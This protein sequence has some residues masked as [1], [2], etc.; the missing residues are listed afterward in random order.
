MSNQ[1]LSNEPSLTAVDG[2]VSRAVINADRPVGT[3]DRNIYGHFAEHLGRCIYEGIWVGEDSDIPNTKGIRNDVL[4]ALQGLDIPV[5][6]W[7][8]GCFADEYHWKDGIGPRESRKRMVNTHWGGVVENNHF[9]THEFLLLCELLGCE[10]YINGNVG[11]GTVQEMQEWVEYMTFAGESPMSALRAAGGHEQPWKVRY[12]GVGNENWGCGGNMRPEYYADEYR[13]YQTYV[14][15][16]GDNKITRIACGANDFNYEWTEVLMREAASH[17]DA[18]TLH[19]YTVPFVWSEKGSATDFDTKAWFE[20]LRKALVMD[21]LVGKHKTIMDKYDPAKR[22]SL[23]VDEWGTWYDVEPGTNPGFLYQQNTMR[24]ALVAAATLHI[25]HKH[26]DRVRMANI[27]QTVNVLQ[28]VV[29]TEGE[30][31]TLTPTYHVFEM[32]KVHQDAELLDMAFESASYTYDGVSIPQTSVSATRGQDGTLNVSLCNLSHEGEAELS[33]ELRGLAAN[34]APIGGSLLHGDALNAHNTVEQ[35]NRVQPEPF[36][37]AQRLEDG[38]IRVTLPAAS[39]AVL[40][41]G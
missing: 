24:D 27:A 10:P 33:F 18:L 15:N 5:L 3:V 36:A 4:K 37:G 8:G 19:Y 22:I 39:V 7:P 17:M 30:R 29:L 12:F 34:D 32:F 9:G 40:R 23:I 6:R 35:P 38:R 28:S 20:T 1:P 21:E 26:S 13:R 14:R 31:M 16:Y 2:P 41:I 11:S 25:F